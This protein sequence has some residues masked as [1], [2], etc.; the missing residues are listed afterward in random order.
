ME[1]RGDWVKVKYD[2]F[3]NDEN[4]KYEGQP[5]QNFVNQCQNPLI[6]WI[7]WK[8]GNKLLI[9]IFLMP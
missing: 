2:C 9:E 5:C 7:R 1:M 6:G 8:Q 4:N 3:Y